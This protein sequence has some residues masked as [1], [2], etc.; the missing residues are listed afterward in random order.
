[1][2]NDLATKSLIEFLSFN[3]LAAYGVDLKT[4]A[5]IYWNQ[6]AEHELGYPSKQVLGKPCYKVLC[7]ISS[8]FKCENNCRHVVLGKKKTGGSIDLALLKHKTGLL[9]TVSLVHLL[10]PGAYSGDSVLLH[11]FKS[12]GSEANIEGLKALFPLLEA[13]DHSQDSSM[14]DLI[15]AHSSLTPREL[16]IT[17]LLAT[18]RTTEEIELE[19]T[20]SRTTVR[21]HIQNILS[22]TGSHNRLQAVAY[23]YRNNLI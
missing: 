7:G 19:L 5:I 8:N 9:K 6:R 4:Q 23:A 13:D 18:G 11:V 3:K 16:E 14:V 15:P 2:Q 12:K 1:M 22:K 21:N 20:I 10:F 17:G